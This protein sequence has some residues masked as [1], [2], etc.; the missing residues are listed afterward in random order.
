MSTFAQVWQDK[1]DEKSDTA[2]FWL[3]LIRDILGFS[4]PEKYIQFE[5]RVELSHVSYIDAYIPSTKIVIEQKSR[6]VDLDTPTRQS[7]GI[8]A[9]PFEQA[10]RYYDW[11][12]LSERGRYI[13][14]CNFQQ[15]RIHDIEHPKAQPR[16]IPLEDIARTDLSFLIRP[17]RELTREEVI[18]LKAGEL[19]GRL[20]TAL[21][22]RYTDKKNPSTLRSLNILCVR[23]VFLLYS[24]DS[25]IFRKAQFHDYLKAHSINAR[26]SLQA[27]F[28]VLDTPEPQRD[29]YTDDDLAA[30]PYVNGGLFSEEN[31]E[32]PKLDGEPLNIIL[33]EM[34]EGFDWSEINPTIFGALFE[35]TLNPET[36]EAGGMHY[37]SIENIHRVIDPLFMNDLKAEFSRLKSTRELLRFQD[38]IA[39][40]TFLDPACG[41]GNF[42]TETYLSLRRLENRIIAALTHG[43]MNFAQGTFTPIKVAI[44]QF[45]GIEINDFAVSVARTAL[46]IAEHQMMK[47]TSRLVAIHDDFIPLRSTAHILEANALLTDWNTVISP[48]K[49]SYIM[50]NPPFYGRLSRTPGQREDMTHVFAAELPGYGSLDY[51]C[52]WYNKAADF[53]RNT[54]IRTAFISTNSISQGES[55]PVFWQFILKK[56]NLFMAYRPFKWDSEAEEKAKVT[57]VIT[58]FTHEDTYPKY[59][60]S[61][62]KEGITA[63]EVQHINGYLLEAPDIYIINRGKQLTPGLMPL[64]NGSQP[65][66]GGNLILSPEERAEIIDRYPEAERF[67][68]RYMGGRD[69][70]Y[71]KLRYCI[72]LVGV[73]PGDYRHIKPFMKRLALVAEKRRQS[74]NKQFRRAADTPMLFT[75]IR[76]PTSEH[77]MVIPYVSSELRPY[78]PMGYLTPDIIV[79]DTLAVIPEVN[80]YLFGV[81]MSSVHMAW[82]DVVAGRLEMRYRYTSA[83]YNNFP[84]PSC[85]GKVRA[86]IEG[87][88][89]RILEVREGCRRSTLADMYDPLS[90]PPELRRAHRENDEAVM[91]AYGFSEEMGELEVV[92]RLMEMYEALKA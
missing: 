30:F 29:P 88:A 79:S 63:K 43:Q 70:L 2:T 39:S 66:D 49:L 15:L 58:G 50:G 77:F 90:M 11:L 18:S 8:N 33:R 3:Q 23:I 85:S 80:L 46:W 89:R 22:K 26:T 34:S 28:T 41:S 16:I 59:I 21:L 40:L 75:S 72:W 61:V 54:N 84:F 55:V 52:A 86:R 81:M 37:T 73:E 67:I 51:V 27:L 68:R 60:Y 83:V 45:Y 32:I 5:K 42:L 44:S 24:E 12:P 35:S 36:R 71:N 56:I 53:I 4:Q 69:F 48:E 82:V 38:K 91:E 87:T 6:D 10:K 19:T 7:D 20:R 14:I 64:K 47:E 57:C 1:G 65:T 62:S 76:Q 25:G 13:I 78:I 9:T 92:V 31:I 17:E 74:S